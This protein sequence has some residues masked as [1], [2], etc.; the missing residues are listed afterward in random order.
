MPYRV[1]EKLA[2]LRR[3]ARYGFAAGLAIFAAGFLLGYARG[4]VL[5]SVP[6]ITLFPAILVAALVGGVRVGFIVAII[7]FFAGWFFFLPP[8]W[9]FEVSATTA[10]A[11]VF[12]WMTAGIQL[13]VIYALHEAV[14]RISAERDRAG[15][16]FK[17]LQHR[18]ANNM[19][20][21][22]GL[23]RIERRVVEVHPEQAPSLLQQAEARLDTMARI[24]RRLYEPQTLDLP[25]TSYL[26][27]LARD[28]L[29]AAG[30]R[31]V[32]CVVEVVPAKLDLERLVTLSL[33]IN[34]LITNSIKHGF[35]GRDSGTISLKLD[36]QAG[37]LILQIHDD[38]KGF[39]GEAAVEGSLGMMII[40]SLVNQLGGTIGWSAEAGT[41]ARLAFPV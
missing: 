14:D 5:A 9:S 3:N 29:Q 17:E 30:A 36:R 37:D 6:F 1:V 32:V 31:N 11:L 23:L 35:A 12:F 15:I 28:I 10:W 40:R 25:L 22:A 18:V 24:H 19:A 21:V 34:E 8:R 7:S 33:L 20:F 41:T 38:G 39:A 27:A 4:A 13:Y 16:L 26:E 2:P